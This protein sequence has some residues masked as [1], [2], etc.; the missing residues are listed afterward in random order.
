M[1]KNVMEGGRRNSMW[2]KVKGS[3]HVVSTWRS[4]VGAMW[5]ETDKHVVRISSNLTRDKITTWSDKI[6]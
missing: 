1:L 2:W 4:H 3:G 5:T 6:K